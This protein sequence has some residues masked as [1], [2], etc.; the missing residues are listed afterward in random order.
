MLYDFITMGEVLE[1]VEDPVK[2]LS[3]L[4]DFLTDDG[5]AF[6]TTPTNA[7][8]IDHISLFESVQEIRTIIHK[9]GFDIVSERSFPS[10]DVTPEE[11]DNLKI[12]IL[13]GAFLKRTHD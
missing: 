8:A 11:A 13:Y 12:A 2:L 10:E 5:I 6:I 1:H 4:K 3:R 9:A 7:P